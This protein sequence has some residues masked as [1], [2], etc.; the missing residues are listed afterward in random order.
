[1][2]RILIAA[3]VLVAPVIAQDLPWDLIDR[4][5]QEP[6]NLGVL[7]T[8]GF[9]GP[10]AL[11]SAAI[12]APFNCLGVNTYMNGMFLSGP[13]D[14]NVCISACMAQTAY[15]LGHNSPQQQCRF[16][17]AFVLSKN[18]AP[19]GW[20]CSASRSREDDVTKVVQ[21]TQRWNAAYATNSGQWRGSYH[22]TISDSVAFY[23]AADPGPC[24]PA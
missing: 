14:P 18:G 21:Y 13:F 12:N 7:D 6:P 24:Q 8:A 23:N 2:R 22:Y 17:N 9:A 19:Q 11:G 3:A 1:M 20:I 15:N 16:V 10:I 4:S 5:P